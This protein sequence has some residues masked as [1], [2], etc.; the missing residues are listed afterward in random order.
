MQV[1]KL[2]V[3]GKGKGRLA[4]GVDEVHRLGNRQHVCDGRHYT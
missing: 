1:E 4:V 2:G 3:D